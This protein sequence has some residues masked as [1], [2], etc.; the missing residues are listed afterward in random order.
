MH[1][2]LGNHKTMIHQYTVIVVIHVYNR[3]IVFTQQES[4]IKQQYCSLSSI[5][6]HPQE[7]SFSYAAPG[8][9]NKLDVEI[10]NIQEKSENLYCIYLFFHVIFYNVKILCI[11]LLYICGSHLSICHIYRVSVI[12]NLLSY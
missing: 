4:S 9:C 3:I 5:Q 7:R 1:S 12:L 6:Q 2:V 10:R 8:E 11:F